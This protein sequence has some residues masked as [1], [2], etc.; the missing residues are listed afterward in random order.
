M[1][2]ITGFKNIAE[3]NLPTLVTEIST[4][5]TKPSV[6]FLSANLGMGKTT[7]VAHFCLYLGIEHTSSPTYSIHNRYQS[8]NAIVDHFDLYRLEDEDS[9]MASGFYD[10]MSERA[11]YKIVEWPER[12]TDSAKKSFGKSYCLQIKKKRRPRVCA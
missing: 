11:D 10:L 7:F 1:K 9:V 6:I 8:V 4:R 2:L 12:L 3:A 5:L